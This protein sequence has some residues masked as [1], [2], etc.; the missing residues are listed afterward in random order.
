[1][2]RLKEAYLIFELELTSSN[3]NKTPIEINTPNSTNIGT[4]DVAVCRNFF[5][6]LKK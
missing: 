4:R 1:M 6:V 3:K 5:I 2:A